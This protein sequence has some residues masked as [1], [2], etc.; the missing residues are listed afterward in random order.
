ML[1]VTIHLGFLFTTVFRLLKQ[2]KIFIFILLLKDTD[3]RAREAFHLLKFFH[4]TI[5]KI[6]IFAYQGCSRCSG[7]FIT[8]S[9]EKNRAKS[10][11]V[12]EIIFKKG[13]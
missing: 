10:I 2:N 9:F 11:S 3:I 12:N 13:K 4:K 6:I 5:D 1:V 8:V 7:D